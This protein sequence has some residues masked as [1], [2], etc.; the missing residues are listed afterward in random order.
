MSLT[1]GARTALRHRQVKRYKRHPAGVK[2]QSD[3]SEPTRIGTLIGTPGFMAPEQAAGDIAL[4]GPATDVFALGALLFWLLTGELPAA[5][6]LP[7]VSRALRDRASAGVSARSSRAASRRAPPI[8]TRTP[9]KSPPISCA[10]AA[11]RPWRPIPKPCS[12]APAA[13]SRPIARSS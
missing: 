13:S 4:I 10:I 5:D 7:R 1:P 8:A 3:A 2:G 6:D 11:G 12:I 9:A